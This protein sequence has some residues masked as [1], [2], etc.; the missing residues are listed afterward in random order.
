M[1]INHHQR[2]ILQVCFCIVIAML[3]FPP[4]V[5]QLPNGARSSDGFGILFWPPKGHWSIKPTVDALQLIAQLAVV[6]LLG[7]LAFVLSSDQASGTESSNRVTSIGSPFPIMVKKLSGP[8]LRIVRGVLVLWLAAIALA[9][10]TSALQL[11]SMDPDVSAQLDWGKFWALMLAKFVGIA[12]LWF[13]NKAIGAVVNRIY[14]TQYG[15][16]TDVIT[17]W[18]DL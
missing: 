6:C 3:L 12:G 7:G 9:I 8:L 14:R 10:V 5:T 2:R 18:R 4:F 16:T 11:V 15:R 1:E 17:K 13:I